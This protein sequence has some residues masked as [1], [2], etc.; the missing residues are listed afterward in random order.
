MVTAADANRKTAGV[1]SDSARTARVRSVRTVEA[2]ART[3]ETANAMTTALAQR[4]MVAEPKF[5]RR[6]RART[7]QM[8]VTAAEVNRR[9]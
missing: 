2:D 9:R 5:V 6:N 4:V 7:A 8:V 3:A 1:A